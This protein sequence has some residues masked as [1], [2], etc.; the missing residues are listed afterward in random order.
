MD[1]LAQPPVLI[2]VAASRDDFT[3]AVAG[4]IRDG[5][6]RVLAAFAAGLALIGLLSWRIARPLG[7]LTREA[8]AIRRFDLAAG[9]LDR[10]LADPR[11]EIEA[12]VGTSAG[13]MN[14]AVLMH[15]LAKGGAPAAREVLAGFCESL[16]ALAS[17][18]PLQPSLLDRLVGLGNM[19][20]SPSWVAADTLNKIFSPYEVN[21]ANA[22]PLLDLLLASVDF[23]A[24]RAVAAPPL[25]VGATNVLTGRLRVFERHEITAEAVMAPAC[26]P[27]LFQAVRVGDAHYR[28]GGYS[29][30]PPIFPLIYMGGGPD[31]VIAQLNP[32]NIPHVPRDTRAF[33]DRMDTLAFNSSLMRE[34]R[35]LKFVTDLIDGGELHRERSLRL[36][37]HTIDAETDLASF[38][39]SS[40]LNA[41]RDFM[42]RLRALDEQKT[43]EFLAAHFEDIG[44]RSRT[45]IVSKFF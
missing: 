25:F 7:V 12:V 26:L 28:D 38:H 24:L 21:P 11:L 13:A 44:V 45:D 41:D 37:M 5:T 32:I 14:A 22:N 40:K 27:T 16:S 6:A 36:N 19:D 34:M 42:H 33:I 31:V 23:D 8:Q 17:A 3:A 43:E 18:S 35:M 10:P 15:G 29:G 9:V 30:N 1:S 20:F 4:A 39:A 2:A